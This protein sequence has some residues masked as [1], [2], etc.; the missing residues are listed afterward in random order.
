MRNPVV[1]MI[2]HA[3]NVAI[4]NILKSEKCSRIVANDEMVA[5]Q[6]APCNADTIQLP[7]PSICMVSTPKTASPMNAMQ[8]TVNSNNFIWLEC[9]ILLKKN[10]RGMG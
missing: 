3:I 5:G 2:M 6:F 9:S 10:Q 7:W 4:E 8:A 1:S